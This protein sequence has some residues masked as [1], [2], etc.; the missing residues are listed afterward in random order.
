[1]NECQHLTVAYI[2]GRWFCHHCEHEFTTA[3][4]ALTGWLTKEQSGPSTGVPSRVSGGPVAEW[5]RRLP[6]VEVE[7]HIIRGEN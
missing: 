3:L 2:E 7:S 6:T 1:M 5:G 4:D